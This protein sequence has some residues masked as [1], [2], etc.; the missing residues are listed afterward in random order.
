[1]FVNQIL[2]IYYVAVRLDVKRLT[3]AKNCGRIIFEIC[4]HNMLQC[5]NRIKLPP[6]APTLVLDTS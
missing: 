6:P 5:F 3:F 4:A 2:I 1:M